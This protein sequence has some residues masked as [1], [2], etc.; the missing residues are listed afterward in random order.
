MHTHT[1]ITAVLLEDSDGKEIKDRRREMSYTGA[2]VFLIVFNVKV[3][4]VVLP[5]SRVKTDT[6][7]Y[8][9][10]HLNTRTDTHK[11]MYAHLNTRTRA[12]I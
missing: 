6:H 1:H 4:V 3:S 10:A 7:K 5:V 2:D 8:I 11:Y 12:S 9:N